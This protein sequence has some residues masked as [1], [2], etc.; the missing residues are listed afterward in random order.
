MNPNYFISTFPDK[1]VQVPGYGNVKL[2]VGYGG[3]FYALV[4]AQRFGLDVRT[5]RTKDISD[6][7]TTVSGN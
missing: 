4:P 7:A 6:V 1:E 5:S 3:A 2:D